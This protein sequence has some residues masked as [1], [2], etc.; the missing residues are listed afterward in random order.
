MAF[1]LGLRR[2]FP[3]GVSNHG[4]VGD[5]ALNAKEWAPV[6]I[7]AFEEKHQDAD[8]RHVGSDGMGELSKRG[9]HHNL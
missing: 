4:Q 6:G 9:L 2:F 8:N 5:L 7:L 3:Q 1:P